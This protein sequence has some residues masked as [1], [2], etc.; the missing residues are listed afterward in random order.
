M[1]RAVEIGLQYS[2]GAPECTAGVAGD[3][4]DWL[5]PAAY[6]SVGES[7]FMYDAFDISIAGGEIALTNVISDQGGVVANDLTPTGY[8]E[9]TL[10]DQV[11]VGPFACDWLAV[12]G[13]AADVSATA[14]TATHA[15]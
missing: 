5:I 12:Y 10:C 15:R 4:G 2:G 6:A 14:S 8:L 11:A 7:F 9:A 13:T 3:F 1:G